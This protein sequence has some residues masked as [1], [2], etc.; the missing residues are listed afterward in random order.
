MSLVIFK[1][2]NDIGWLQLNRPEKRNAL[3][4]DLLIE[5]RDHLL[6]IGKNESIRVIIVQGNGPVFCAGHDLKELT[7]NHDKPYYQKI[8]STCSEVMQLFSKLPQPVIAMV[9]GAATAAGC[10]L[11][12]SCDLA[13]ASE[14]AVF[15]TPGVDIGL[16]CTTPMVPLYR[17]IGL[18]R[19]LDMLLTGRFVSASEAKEFGLVNKVVTAETLKNEVERLARTIA[20]KSRFTVCFGKKAFYDQVDMNEKEAYEYAVNAIIENCLHDDAEEGIRAQL[21]KRKPEWK[22]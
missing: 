8:F 16:F 6:N 19:S 5:L 13:V 14:D 10:Q 11:V 9:Q 17:L 7:G 4:L 20:S 3:S 15:S 12:A 22:E 1:Q 2:K 18:R 21:E